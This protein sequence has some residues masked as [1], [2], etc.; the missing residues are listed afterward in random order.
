[1]SEVRFIR[2]YPTTLT[3]MG[4]IAYIFLI[5]A[6]LPCVLS[7]T[8][9]TFP[10]YWN[11]FTWH[12]KKTMM[13]L[14]EKFGFT[15]NEG[16]QFRGEKIA[17]FYEFNHGLYPYYKDYDINKPVHRGSPQNFS[18]NDFIEHLKVSRENITKYIKNAGSSGLGILDFEEWRPLNDVNSVKKQHIPDKRA[19]E[20]KNHYVEYWRLRK[21]KIKKCFV[22]D[23][24]K[25]RHGQMAK[26]YEPN[27]VWQ[28]EK[29]CP[30][31]VLN[32]YKTNSN[33]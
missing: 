17:I 2:F 5:I 15:Q 4:F 3:T 26:V 7:A 21:I 27:R 16:H 1:M 12:C 8:I 23:V 22:Q 32:T 30:S 13:P 31:H 9:P 24:V 20:E 14:L 28:F 6:F 25:G 10:V 29:V 19:S 18:A 33:F 11:I